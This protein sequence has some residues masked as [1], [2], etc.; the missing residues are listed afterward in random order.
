MT[1][2]DDL[3]ALIQ[4]VNHNWDRSVTAIRNRDPRPPAA[5]RNFKIIDSFD[6]TDFGSVTVDDRGVLRSIDLDSY[7]V[8]N[9]NESHVIAAV[10]TTLNSAFASIGSTSER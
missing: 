1:D 3:Y 8:S 2:F 5:L 7:E 4:E 6:G 10:I 9:S